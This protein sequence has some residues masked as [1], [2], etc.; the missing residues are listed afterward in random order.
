ML[1]TAWCYRQAC[2]FPIFAPVVV[3]PTRVD[4]WLP[5]IPSL[6]YVYLSY[7]LLLPAL[8]L[9]CQKY[10]GFARVFASGLAC[11]LGNVV[12]Y[13]FY[14]T[15]LASRPEAPQ[16]SLLSV[17]YGIDTTLC[18]LPSGHVA[19]PVSLAVASY[20]VAIQHHGVLHRFW[21]AVLLC[22]AMWAFLIAVSALFIRQHY[23]VDIFAGIVF[24]GSVAVCF[25]LLLQV[26]PRTLIALMTEWLVII[27][28][29]TAALYAN[30]VLG[31][32]VAGVIISTRQHALLM[33]FHDGVHY[34]IASNKRINDLVINALAGIPL[35]IPVHVYRAIHLSHHKYLGTSKDPERLLL[36]WGQPWNYQPLQGSRLSLQLFG[37]ASGINSLIMIVRYL[38]MSRYDNK[39]ELP[40][41]RTYIELPLMFLCFATVIFVSYKIWPDRTVIVLLLWF[42]PYLTLTQFLQKIRSFTEHTL[43]ESENYTM[44]WNPGLMGRL[45]I[46][47]YNINYHREHHAHPRVPWDRLPLYADENR[48]RQGADLVKHLWAGA[49]HHKS[50]TSQ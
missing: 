6:S 30:I 8:I 11:G 16:D 28:V 39:F 47:P 20:L 33:L 1:V 24:G 9:F 31:Y 21:K 12:I 34:L 38:M 36:Y 29:M 27:M 44:S 37:D 23:I 41:T 3:E 13:M 32:I 43:D 10:D 2:L 15:M 7:F 14:P 19:L 50:S 48:A 25:A 46:W 22:F 26:Y 4:R 18:A 35:L 17:I 42:V 49:R 45:S 40:A 5:F